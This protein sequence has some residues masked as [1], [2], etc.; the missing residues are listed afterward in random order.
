MEPL[1]KP[2]TQ[3]SQASII[4]R[5]MAAEYEAALA[6]EQAFGSFCNHCLLC[7]TNLYLDWPDLTELNPSEIKNHAHDEW[8]RAAATGC[9]FCSIIVAVIDDAVEQHGCSIPGP[10]EYG[11]IETRSP[12]RTGIKGF[13]VILARNDVTGRYLLALEHV[14]MPLLVEAGEQSEF[15]GN[16]TVYL[17]GQSLYC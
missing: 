15:W 17:S 5:G 12:T 6:A 13:Q 11:C 3:A 9:P 8:K 2:N 1:S 10:D 7:G 4:S 14:W 16:I